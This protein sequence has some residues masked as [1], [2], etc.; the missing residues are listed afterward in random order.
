MTLCR[1]PSRI[2]KL[3]GH[4]SKSA[5]HHNRTVGRCSLHYL[6]CSANR[7][8]ILYRS[9]AKLHHDAFQLRIHQ[10]PTEVRLNVHFVSLVCVVESMSQ[11]KNPPASCFWRWVLSA[12]ISLSCSAHQA[13]SPRRHVIRVDVA[14]VVIRLAFWELE[15]IGARCFRT[16][17]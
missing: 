17:I 5:D 8:G 13:P 3:V 9:T 1:S 7:S 2:H 16:A 6:A 12:A 14:I 4:F 10:F 15:F 11:I